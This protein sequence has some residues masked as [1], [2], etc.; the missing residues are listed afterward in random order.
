MMDSETVFRG[1]FVLA[2]IAMLAIRI[3]SQSRVLA[4]K[5]RVEVRESGLA[6]TAGSLAA[7][8]ALVFGAEYL[9]SPGLFSFAYVLR[10]PDWLRWL[11]AF[12][13]AGGITLLGFSHYYLGKSFH[14]LVVL[15]DEHTLVQ[16]GPYR[17]IRHPIYLAYLMNYAG[18]G[19]LASNWVLT[20]VPAGLY[21]ILVGLRM[22]K[23]EEILQTQFGQAYDE[24]MK[25]T[26]RLFPRIKK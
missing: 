17:W 26:G 16:A 2:F 21:V 18:G 4:D 14:S 24:Y 7:L 22:G 10:Y 15:K 3:P 12:V 19:L 25:G 1:L 13:L 9:F 23:E 20:L 6:L 11:G 8:T 5:R